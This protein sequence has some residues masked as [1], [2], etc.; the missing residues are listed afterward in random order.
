L[1]LK[2]L[3]PGMLPAIFTGIRIAA[4][5]VFFMLVAAEMLGSHAGLGAMVHRSAMNYQV[6]QMYAGATCIVVLGALLSQGL[7]WLQAGLFWYRDESGPLIGSQSAARRWRPGRGALVTAVVGVAALL[8]LGAR[9]VRRVNLEDVQAIY[10]QAGQ[11]HSTGSQPDSP[12]GATEPVHEHRALGSAAGDAR[13][14][15]AL[16]SNPVKLTAGKGRLRLELRDTSGAPVS[17]G[18]MTLSIAMPGMS[19]PNVD[20]RSTS[21]PGVYEVLVML[22]MPGGWWVRVEAVR[23]NGETAHARFDFEAQ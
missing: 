14:K 12:A 4:I 6:T 7:Q 22:G 18:K 8:I 2:V 23:P 16:L 11:T 13:L 3:L 17:D 20:A 15:L 5:L 10:G 19:V 1:F 9:Q 21:E